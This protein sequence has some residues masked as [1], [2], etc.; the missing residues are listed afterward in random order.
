MKVYHFFAIVA[1][2]KE[3][4]AI[5]GDKLRFRT[6]GLRQRNRVFTESIDSN[7]IFS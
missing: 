2:G 1:T 3:M 6:Y 4:G 7:E 5:E